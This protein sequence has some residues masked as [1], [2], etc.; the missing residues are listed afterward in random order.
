MSTKAAATRDR[1]LVAAGALF[2]LRGYHGV[3]LEEVGAAAGV[4]RQAV[5]K[6]FG[7]KARL[8]L[9]ISDRDEAAVGLPE[10][11]RGVAGAPDA[12][13]ALDR[14]I[15][16]QAN[17][18]AGLHAHSSVVYAARAT[19]AAAR[20]VWDGRMARRR[21]GMGMIIG[22]LAAEGRLKD[23]LVPEVAADLLWAVLSLHTYEYL[24]IGR[25][26]SLEEY[27]ARVGR[28]AR[29]ALLKPQD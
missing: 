21:A 12:L 27:R 14:M 25:G 8:L 6:H 10:R 16:T 24:V 23:G 19:D 7:S 15:E 4:S 29:A 9:A 28:L 26:W 5:Y 1:I 22:R 17:V 18:D 20:E 3:G 13:T 2:D 11:L